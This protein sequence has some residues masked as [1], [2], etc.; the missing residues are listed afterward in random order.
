MKT[1]TQ[2]EIREAAK[3]KYGSGSYW[4]GVKTDAFRDGV[5]WILNK[6]KKLNT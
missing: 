2:K 4:Q 3:S 5:K 6:L 1:P